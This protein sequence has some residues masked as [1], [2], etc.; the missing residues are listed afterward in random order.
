MIKFEVGKCCMTCD[1]FKV[2]AVQVKTPGKAVEYRDLGLECLEASMPMRIGCEHR[3]VCR[4]YLNEPIKAVPVEM[5][6]RGDGGG[7]R[8][9][10]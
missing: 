7:G 4:D 9:D 2:E 10:Q 6:F 8:G 5:L 3:H 1:Y